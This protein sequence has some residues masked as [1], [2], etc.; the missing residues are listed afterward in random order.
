MAGLGPAPKHP[1]DRA[2]TNA[3]PFGPLTKLPPEGYQGVIPDWPETITRD[4]MEDD[5]LWGDLWRTPQAA[6]WVRMGAGVA[7]VVARYVVMQRLRQNEKIWAEMRQIEDRLGLNP[8]A[9]LRLRWEVAPDEVERKRAR[10]RP[11]R[12]VPTD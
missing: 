1:D 6:A 2:R 10:S 4:P 9:M 12:V 3:D 8:L 11:V 5:L 7:R